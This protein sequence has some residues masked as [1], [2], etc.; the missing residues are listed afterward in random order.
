MS[1]EATIKMSTVD[2]LKFQKQLP[3]KNVKVNSADPDQTASEAV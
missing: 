3:V 2:V 1:L